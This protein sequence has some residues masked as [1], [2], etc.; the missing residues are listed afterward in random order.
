MKRL[1]AEFNTAIIMITHDLGVIA[2][3]AD[4]VLVM[5]AGRAME[6]VNRRDAYYQPHHPYTVG[7]LDSLPRLGA[8]RGR[9]RPIPGQPPSL[10]HPPPGCPFHPRC[11]YAMRVC[12]SDPPLV[13]VGGTSGHLSAC[14]LPPSFR[15]TGDAVDAARGAYSA[16][17]DPAHD[18][19]ELA[20]LTRGVAAL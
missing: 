9:M 6:H 2:D 7:L 17:H 3:M 16:E 14:F 4:D 13:E 5:Y 15:G 19:A 12:R 8:T 10:I 20:D 18:E 11:R 1:Q